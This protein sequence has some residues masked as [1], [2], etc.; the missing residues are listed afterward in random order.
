M[1]YGDGELQSKITRR[2]EEE[3]LRQVRIAETAGEKLPLQE[4]KSILKFAISQ[5]AFCGC[6]QKISRE[7]ISIYFRP[8]S[9][10][11]LPAS[12]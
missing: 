4:M 5:F 7:E 12:V 3:V 6:T 10:D 8:T 9:P 2:G 11:K 1:L